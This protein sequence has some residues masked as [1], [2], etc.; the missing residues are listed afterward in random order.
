MKNHLNIICTLLILAAGLLSSCSGLPN[1]GAL[2]PAG[3]S[4]EVSIED[5]KT[6]WEEYDIY[7]S[8]WYSTGPAALMF[9]PRNN[10]TT[11]TGNAW[12]RVEEEAEFSKLLERVTGSFSYTRIWAIIGPE[13]Q[14]LGY[15]ITPTTQ[16]F[17]K[18]VDEKTFYVSNLQVPPSGP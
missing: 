9:D 12:T 17:I 1:Y 15:M 2:G 13:K 3:G 11:L 14:L 18:M 8:T 4:G 7:Y 16:V 6:G 5:L 10:D